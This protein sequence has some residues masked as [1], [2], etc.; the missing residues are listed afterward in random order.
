[1]SKS[2]ERPGGKFN[3]PSI[4]YILRKE[5]LEDLEFSLPERVSP[6]I[7][8]LK[9]LRSLHQICTDRELSD[10]RRILDDFKENFD[11]LYSNFNLNMTLKM[12][13]IINH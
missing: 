6:F 5:V 12:H 3:G 8:L 9:N 13:I 1:M 11:Y 2:G 7:V 10:Y 4:K